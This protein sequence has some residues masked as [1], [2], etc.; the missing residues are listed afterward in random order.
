MHHKKIRIVEKFS[1]I[2]TI[3]IVII[4]YQNMLW[5]NG[6]KLKNKQKNTK[7]LKD[8]WL[9]NVNHAWKVKAFATLLSI[10]MI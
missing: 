10:V 8:S 4:K 2:I 6:V 3:I 5:I 7:P 9:S 1:V